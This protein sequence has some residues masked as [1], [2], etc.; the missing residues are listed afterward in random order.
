MLFEAEIGIT[1]PPRVV[2]PA[3][4]ASVQLLAATISVFALRG[5]R[6]KFC[7]WILGFLIETKP[8]TFASSKRSF[9][10]RPLVA[11]LMTCTLLAA[12]ALA[13][14]PQDAPTP[15]A[16]ISEQYDALLDAALTAL[17]SGKLTEGE[18][19]AFSLTVIDESRAD[20]FAVLGIALKKQG[21]AAEAQAVFR[22]ARAKAPSATRKMIELMDAFGLGVVP[23]P[24]PAPAAAP[25]AGAIPPPA[26]NAPLD[27]CEVLAAAPDPAVVTDAEARTRMTATKLPWKVRDRKTGIVLLLCPPGEFMMGSPDSEVGHSNDET[28][29]RVPITKAFYLSETEVTQESWQNVMGANPSSFEGASNPVE[30]VSWNDCQSFCQSSG[31]RLAS[32][33][34]WEYAC[35]AGTTTAYSFGASITKQQANF[36]SPKK[37]GRGRV[38]CG[39]LPANHWGFREMHGNVWEWCE[40]RYQATASSVQE[41]VK[42]NSSN[43]V[44]RGG[45]WNV[46]SNNVR[47]SYRHYIT[48]DFTYNNIG[49][50]VARAPL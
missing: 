41:A 47:S 32:E 19:F 17:A 37:T 8:M 11:V 36:D 28:Q 10:Q 38:A 15:S 46:S 34:E 16:A 5:R 25:A 33:S 14:T 45:A 42:A 35:R 1:P 40:D 4:T 22:T 7:Q 20:G 30:Q 2:S 3:A 29:H 50:R 24:T 21:K 9:L 31:L 18:K 39:S 13:R 48:A 49:F 26:A 43:R 44:L 6:P 27:W 12:T 23:S